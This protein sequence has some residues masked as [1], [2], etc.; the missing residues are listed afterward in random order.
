VVS[1]GYKVELSPHCSSIGPLTLTPLLIRKSPRQLQHGKFDLLM[2]RTK[3]HFEVTEGFGK[4]SAL[5][6]SKREDPR[7]WL[8]E[9]TAVGIRF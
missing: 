7:A 9:E 5:R 1:A 4:T 8:S 3:S 6:P 2:Q